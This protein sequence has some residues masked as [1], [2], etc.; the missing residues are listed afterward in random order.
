[1]PPS[2]AIRHRSSLRASSRIIA[3]QAA[4][5]CASRCH[6]RTFLRPPRIIAHH[7]ASSAHQYAHR[8]R[9]IGA[10]MPHITRNSGK[11]RAIINRASIAHQS[12]HQPRINHNL[13][14][15]HR[16]SSRINC[17]ST[18]INAHQPSS[19]RA[20]SRIFAHH[21]ASSR[22]NPSLIRH[23]SAFLRT[24]LRQSTLE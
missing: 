18:R 2:S 4:H 17:A 5:F 9:I 12:A 16:A 21:R 10:S 11:T 19:K 24:A 23:H 1:M 15:H 20:L 14:A 7:R 13:L 6:T 3:H 22:I 8:P